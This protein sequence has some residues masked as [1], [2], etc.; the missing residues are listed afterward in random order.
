VNN[1]RA[2]QSHFNDEIKLNNGVLIFALQNRL[3]AINFT[4]AKNQKEICGK[5]HFLL[6]QVWTGL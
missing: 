1:E 5:Y 6:P 4:T 2:G 3:T